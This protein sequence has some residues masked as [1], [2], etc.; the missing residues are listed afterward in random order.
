MKAHKVLIV[1][2]SA[3]VRQLL[4]EFISTDP[5]LTVV[6]TAS[7]ADQARRKIKELSP[8]VITLDIE[9][10]GMDG[11]SFL[12][13]LMRLRPMPVVMISSLT[14]AGAD[15]TLEALS[16]GA[17]DFISKPTHDI[18]DRLSEFRD[19]IVDKIRAAATARVRPAQGAAV[20]PAIRSRKPDVATENT[21]IAIG[22]SAGGT[23][24]IRE[25]LSGLG[26]STPPVLIVQHIPRE[27][28]GAFARRLDRESPLRVREATHESALER[29]CALVAPGGLHLRLS[30]NGAYCTLDAEARVNRHRPSVDCLF[31]SVAR[32]RVKN[33]IGVLLTGM[34]ADGARGLLAMHRNGAS[35]IAQDEQ[36]S[37]VWGMPREAVALGAAQK[38][39]SI[40][41]VAT[42]I[43]VILEAQRDNACANSPLPRS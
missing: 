26:E 13:H 32:S 33:A 30:K 17:V 37:V 43:N 35:T 27:F 12:R 23:E 5:E 28:S 36:T 1:D 34:G 14:T 20:K 16:I 38:I 22:A 31:E 42:E 10:P 11:I 29:G 21:V 9:M 2:D 7:N 15:L 3:L 8:D 6:G 4:R 24:A 41:E 39:V 18:K 19:E 25:V 40:H